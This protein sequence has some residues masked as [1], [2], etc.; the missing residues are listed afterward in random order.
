MGYWLAEPY[1]GKGLMTEAIARFTA[2]AFERF[3]LI[4][5]YAEP[6]ATNRSSCRVFGEGRLRSGGR[7]RSSVV[8][9]GHLLDQFLYA[10]VRADAMAEVL[11]STLPIRSET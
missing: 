2:F 6:H 8:K 4:R 3:R 9:D 11:R 5:I 1:W 10:L 7:L